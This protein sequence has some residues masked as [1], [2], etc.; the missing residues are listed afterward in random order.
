M[1]QSCKNHFNV[2]HLLAC[3][4]QV[5]AVCLCPQLLKDK[6]LPLDVRLRAQSLLESCDGGSV[7]EDGVLHEQ[8]GLTFGDVTH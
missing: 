8:R 1:T 7:G 4:P 5:L 6:S 3:C 2:S